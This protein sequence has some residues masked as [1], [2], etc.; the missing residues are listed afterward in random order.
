MNKL[1][2]LLRRKINQ[3]PVDQKN[4]K[5]KEV[6]NAKKVRVKI[7]KEN[8]VR[9]EL[10]KEI[11]S[12]CPFCDST[13]VGHFHIHHI[14]E[15]P[16]NNSAINLLLVCPTC[17]S[18]I[19]KGDITIAEV[20]KKKETLIA[21]KQETRSA[22]VVNFN[23]KVSNAIVGDNNTV[24]IKNVKSTKQ[25]Y[26]PG[27]IG[28]ESLKANYVSHLIG[29]YNE[30]KEYEVGKAKVN[31]AFFSSH[32]KKRYKIG[33]TRTINNLP[34][35]KFEELVEYIQYRI[36]GTMLAKTKGRNHKNYSSFEEYKNSQLATI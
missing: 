25:K 19:T 9:A 6:N 20:V 1:I 29:R 2:G 12:V 13:D 22:K 36:D 30:Y 5:P 26:P 27:C 24:T 18:K 7:P 15:E 23:T 14:D 8:K 35:E 21:G 31:Y 32:L 4:D 16:A 3:R 28:Y 11:G 10:Q 17:H 34:L 33:P